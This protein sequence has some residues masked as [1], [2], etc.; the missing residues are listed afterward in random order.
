MSKLIVEH[1]SKVYNSDGRQIRALDDIS[2]TI[3][4]N[5]IVG[6]L[7]RNGSGKTT[8]VKSCTNLITFEG[9]IVLADGDEKRRL[10]H[11][12]YSAV[13]EGN[14]N[15]F[16]KLTVVENIRY[17]AG[18]RGIKYSK[19]K[20]M[21]MEL[22]QRL[23][24]FEKKDCLVETLSR[25]MKQKVALVCAL[26]VGTPMLFLDEPTLGLDVESRNQLRDFFLHDKDFV[27][28]RLIFITS[29]DLSFIREVTQKQFFIQNGKVYDVRLEDYNPNVYKASV[30][31]I[32]VPPEVCPPGVCYKDGNIL[33]DTQLVT[34]SDAI[35]FF[36]CNG[37]ELLELIRLNNDIESFYLDFIK[38]H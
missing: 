5:Q 7:G 38:M 13:L 3:D 37:I 35:R 23:S 28:E 36:E 30:G 6:L 15:I 24:L 18:L 14:R 17:F 29:H 8:F 1:L 27:S 16:W 20:G 9:S 2:F 31:A 11:K 22:L 32:A 10:C 12:D 34:I 21:S 33:I 4:T 26:V 25:G 19:V